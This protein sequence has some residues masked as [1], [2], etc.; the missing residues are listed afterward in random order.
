MRRSVLRRA[1]FVCVLASVIGATLTLSGVEGDERFLIKCDKPCASVVSTVAAL[2]GTVTQAYENIDAVAVSVPR[3]RARD[4]SAAIG[5]GRLRK[6]VIVALP[7]RAA[8][9][10]GEADGMLDLPADAADDFFQDLPAN[11][12][13]NNGLT[14]ASTLHGAGIRGQ[15]IV[16][17]VI[18]SGTASAIAM[19]GTPPG[20]TPTVIGGESLVPPA[21][22]AVASATSRLNDWHG[23]AVAGMIAAHANFLFSN[24]QRLVQSLNLYAPGSVFLCGTPPFT[25]CPPTQSVV[26]MFGTAPAAEIYALKVFPSQGGGA[27]GSRIIAAMDRV[28]TLRRNFN[29]GMPTTPVSGTGTENDPFQYNALDIQVV[30]MSLGGPTLFAGRDIEDE[31]TVAMVD[32]GIT[33]TTAAG[34]AGFAAMTGGSPGTGL[35]GLTVGAATTPVH[36]RVVRDNQ[37]G[38]GFGELYRPTDHVQTAYLSARGPTADGRLDPELVA[39]GDWSYVNVFGAVLDGFLVSC[40]TPGVPPSACLPRIIFTSGASF[41]SPTVAGA[42]ALLRQQEPEA[43]A[44]Q[45]RNALVIGANPTVVQDESGAI[46]QGAGF[47][48]VPASLELLA[49]GDVPDELPGAYRGRHH[50]QRDHSSHD[51]DSDDDDDDE[52]GGGGKSVIRNVRKLGF[53]PV[54]FVGIGTRSVSTTCCPGRSRSSSSRAMSAPIG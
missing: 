49:S 50:H 45:T 15:N 22:D 46:D 13:Y 5:E 52:V 21:E 38:V 43:S 31:L 23:T 24:T 3:G 30:N 25:S 11:Y 53:K 32:A 8:V 39:N 4:L 54:R 34:N 16:V 29:S 51:D 20:G 40:G 19:L 14:G 48:D 36:E 18:D 28:I 1:A 12:N 33:L 17:A 10:A 7:P 37:L 41:A 44:V 6:D 27:P 47:L 2:G 26:P 35:G 9:A 42:A